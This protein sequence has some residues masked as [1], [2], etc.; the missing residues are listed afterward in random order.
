MNAAAST[1]LNPNGFPAAIEHLSQ[2]APFDLMEAEHLRQL[3]EGLNLGYYAKGEVI[4]SSQQGDATRYF[5][6]KQGVVLSEQGFSRDEKENTSWELTEGESFPLSALLSKRS[7]SST[8]TAK[9]DTFCY[10]LD[11]R[12]FAKLL[13]VSTQFQD[14]CTRRMAHLLEQS[15]QA[16]QAQYAN[17]SSGQQSMNTPLANIVRRSPVTC[18]P[19]TPVREVLATMHDLGIGS[20]VA[21]EADKPVGI[22]TLHDVLNRVALAEIDLESPIIAV[23]STGLTSLPPTAAA[24]E[25]ALVM[26][27]QGF[28]HVLVTDND[29]LVGVISEKDLFTLQ[30]VGLRQI[31]ATIRNAADLATLQQAAGDIRQL[32]HNMLAQGVAAEQL[33]QFISTLNDLLTERIIE[34]ECHDAGIADSPLCQSGICWLALGSE[35]RFEQTLNTD[36]DNGLIFTVPEGETAE[37]IRALL[38]PV[39]KRINDALDACGFPLC[40]GNVMASNPEWCLSLDEWKDKFSDWIFRGDMPVLLNAS[41][42]FDFRALYGK[43]ELAQELRS[44]LN[45]KIKD[46]RLFLR[47]MTQNALGNRPP[48]GLVRDFVVGEG[49]KLD[50]KF[51]GITPFVDA[52]RIFGLAAGS[53]ETATIRRLRAAAEN[54]HMEEGEVEGWVEAFLYIQLLRL[55]LQHEQSE[56]GQELSNKVDPDTLNNLDRRILKEAFRQG[57]RIQSVLEK[58]FQF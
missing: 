47:N 51:N 16:I 26:A 20:M 58:Y 25:A 2:H 22:F 21:T 30:R 19:Q 56:A 37:H 48:L 52:A 36:Q 7:S 46:N 1:P 4:V 9:E 49:N 15:K 29:K 5:I 38:L 12:D 57:R 40:K 14:Y 17:S 42:F 35:G 3:V 54:W 32:A 45:D 27:K 10:E 24:Y 41:I 44:W 11:A 33:T 55:R 28:R 50:L 6:I 23:M 43:R 31:S 39:A 13:S 18:A 53:A 8:Y 34:L